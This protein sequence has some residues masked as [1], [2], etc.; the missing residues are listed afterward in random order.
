[1]IEK[2]TYDNG[3]ILNPSICKCE[4]E[5]SCNIGW[6][7]IYKKCKWRKKLINKLVEEFRKEIDRNE[8]IHNVTVNVYGKVLYHLYS[9]INHNAH[10]TYRHW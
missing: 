3:F 5:K 7:I 1:M 4:N 10:N 9:I 6:F 2:G 8:M